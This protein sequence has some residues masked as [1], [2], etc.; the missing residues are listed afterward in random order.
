MKISRLLAVAA[1]TALMT[2]GLSACSLSGSSALASVEDYANQSV[3]WKKCDS[4]LLI[5]SQRQSKVFAK[6]KTVDCAEV[7][8]PASYEDIAGSPALLLPSEVREL[9]FPNVAQLVSQLQLGKL[10]L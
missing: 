9:L 3:S 1:S 6:T 7:L 4:D 10:Q 2:F 8:V 5:D